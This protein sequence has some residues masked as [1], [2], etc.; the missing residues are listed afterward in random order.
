MNVKNT[1]AGVCLTLSLLSPACSKDAVPAPTAA[2]TAPIEFGADDTA[3]VELGRI[4][5]TVTVRGTLEPATKVHVKSPMAG[6]LNRV[7]VARASQVRAGQVLATIDAR[8]LAAASASA[9]A[10]LASA[11]RD[12]AAAELLFKQ[13]ALPKSDF[14]RASAALAAAR[15]QTT[16]ATQGVTDATITAQISGTVIERM[17]EPNET[18]MPGQPLFTIVNMSALDLVAHVTPET[19]RSIRVGQAV[20]LTS[21]RLDTSVTGRVSRIEAIADPATRL[22]T[23]F[24]RLA[25]PDRALLPGLYVEG[26]IDT[27]TADAQKVPMVPVEAVRNEGSESVVYVVEGDHLRRVPVTLGA[28]DE[29]RG[30]VEV[31]AGLEA[32]A[33]VVLLPTADLRDGMPITLAASEGKQGTS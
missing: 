30:V 3:A 28:R 1:F 31:T 26:A 8:T 24:I 12:F 16:G 25:N 17:V 29:S 9:S 20:T 13:G 22:I 11:E 19:V 21:H 27:S 15:A 32:P 23:V 14:L 2:K 10:M 5:S 6:R 33:R 4:G 7:T 18:V